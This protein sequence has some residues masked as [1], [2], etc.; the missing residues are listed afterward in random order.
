MRIVTEREP[1]GAPDTPSAV[2]LGFFDG[3]HLGHAAVIETAAAFARRNNL[4]LCV[5]TFSRGPKQAR[6][7][8]LSEAQKHARL[9]ALGVDTCYQ[10]PFESVKGLEPE[11]FFNE[12]LLGEYNAKALSCG[13]NFGFGSRRAG[14]VPL[15]KQ[16]CG[17]TGT[18]LCVAPT[19]QYKGEAVSSSRIRKALAEGCIEDVNA[20]L[21]YPYQVDAPVEHGKKLGSKLGM[22]T[23]NQH[24]PVELQS[25]AFGVYITSTLVDGQQWP[26][27][28][29]FGSRPTVDDGAPSCETFIPG[30]AGDLYGKNIKVQFYKKIA[31]TQRFETVEK[32]ALAVGDWARQALEYFGG[33]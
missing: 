32:L 22:P 13:E 4:R 14:G 21:G 15:L 3:V 2:A 10:P 26:S 16:L 1:R 33:A 23:I 18:A 7:L 8:I 20:M 9:A 17:Q 6:G 5:F 12:M 29:G 30:Y 27:A 28:T 31:E 25:P 24:L 19:A 11:A